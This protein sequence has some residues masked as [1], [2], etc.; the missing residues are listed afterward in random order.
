[1]VV[2]LVLIACGVLAYRFLAPETAVTD[3]QG[4]RQADTQTIAEK[5]T[6]P[7]SSLLYPRVAWG[8]DGP[9]YAETELQLYT[10]MIAALMRW[11]GEGEWA[12]HLLS[13]LF[14]TGAV[15][16]VFFDQRRRR[17][18]L[19]AIFAVVAFLGTRSMVHIA[20]SIQPDSLSLLG[21]VLAF[22]ALLRYRDYQKTWDL[23]L[24]TVFFGLATLTKPTS[25]QLGI[26]SALILFLTARPLLKRPGI[27]VA[28]GLV[29]FAGAAYLWHARHVYL[30]G[31]NSF[32]LFKG[33]NEKVPTLIELT[34][35]TQLYRAIRMI[36]VWGVGM[37]STLALVVVALRRKL[38]AEIIG[39]LAGNV[40]MTILFIRITSNMSGS[41]YMVPA[42]LIGSEA[43][44]IIATD[45]AK[46]S[47]VPRLRNLAYGGLGLFL[48]VQLF[49][50]VRFRRTASI[51]DPD[52]FRIHEAGLA[53]SKLVRPNDRII[54]RSKLY[55]PR[56]F[57]IAHVRGWHVNRFAEDGE[58]GDAEK[59]DDRVRHGAHY[60][61]DP[62]AGPTPTAV[63]EW[64]K[65]HHARVVVRTSTGAI[66]DLT[67]TTAFRG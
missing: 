35:P 2:V 11:F 60:Y 49:T 28:W 9:G 67:P 15:I 30:L 55:D 5:L 23:V 32:G 29:L 1:M 14:V 22:A 38:S 59:F 33:G 66:W 40:V 12:G 58:K 61:V 53:L 16:V 64:L 46:T 34:S 41:H 10:G 27:W 36:F 6:E 31:G 43:A 48:A 42:A 26:S 44:A 39:L 18:E 21:Y 47:W 65:Q 13:A 17:G 56:V 20:T 3:L 45:L 7:G 37:L 25:A 52:A 8:A 24:Y 19:A 62:V 50:V 54:V 51:I 63:D 4:W 57:Y